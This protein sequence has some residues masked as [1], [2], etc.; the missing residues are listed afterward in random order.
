[1]QVAVVTPTY[2]EADNLGRLA[3][4][5]FALPLD[6][7]LLVVDDDSPDGTGRV[8]DELEAANPGRM[9]VLH[10]SGKLGLSTAYL[11]GFQRALQAG[12]QAVAQMD[13]DLSHDPSVL[14]KMVERLISFDVVLGSRYVPGGRVD[15]RWPLWRKGL[16][17]WGSFYARTILGLPIRDA[18]S[19]FRLWRRETLA[20]MPLDRVRASG[21]VFQVEMAYLAHRLGYRI[22][23]VPIYF[24][25]R[26]WG[27]S[28]MSFQIQV[29][30]A[31][32]VWQVLW[33]YRDLHQPRRPAGTL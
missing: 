31:F 17:A 21:Y 29:E 30:A 26:R 27:K 12:A 28:K 5:L 8:A 7:H 16:S 9:Q 2:N 14:P 6:L 13:A 11:Q 22:G 33:S 20:G 25:D 18:T 3:A 15:E 23:E 1:L 4:A 24:S 32:R 19:G 10:R